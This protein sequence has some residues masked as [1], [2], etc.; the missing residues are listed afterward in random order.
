[1]IRLMLVDI[2]MPFIDGLSLSEILVEK[3]PQIAIVIV[4]G[5]DEFEYAKKAVK[6]GVKDYIL[7]PFDN[8]ELM[9][10]LKKLKD[11]ILKDKGR[12][13]N[14]LG[15][16]YTNTGFYSGEAYENLLFHMKS[17]NEDKVVEEL[18][19]IFECITEKKLSFIYSTTLCSALISLCL[20]C[21]TESGKN[22]E[23]A[24]GKDFSPLDEIKDKETMGDLKE[25]IIGLFQKTLLILN[26]GKTTR[27]GKITEGA[28]KYIQDRFGDEDL[29]VEKIAASLYINS[30]YLRKVFTENTG[31][32]II[33]YITGVRMEKAG[34]LLEK[35]NIKHSEIARMLGYSDACYFS[36]CFK[37]YY[38]V[39]PSEYELRKK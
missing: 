13:Y 3:H 33:D 32:T 34:Q 16:D 9:A 6:L 18:N 7:K 27:A 35:P 19:R 28:K 8:E 29:S 30:R 22:I 31:M 11:K 2:N 14:Y 1:M 12:W 37:K 25:W 24:V 20:S 4:T 5:H 38:G 10:T 26:A 17:R 36:K 39:S 23:E 21:L 15:P